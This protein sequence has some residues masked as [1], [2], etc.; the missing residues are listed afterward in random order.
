MPPTSLESSPK[1]KIVLETGDAFASGDIISGHVLRQSPIVDPNTSISL[2]LCA[3]SRSYTAVGGMGR[4]EFVSTFNLLDS[5]RQVLQIH[6][7]PIHIP[8][9]SPDSDYGR[10]PF[11]ITLPKHPDFAS[12]KKDNEDEKTFLPFEDIASKELPPSFSVNTGRGTPHTDAFVEYYLE[13]TMQCNGAQKHTLMSRKKDREFQAILPLQIRADLPSMSRADFSTQHRAEPKQRLVS[14][15]LV[16]GVDSRLGVGQHIRKMVKSSQVPGYSFSLQLDFAT[17]LQI[18]NPNPIPLQ[19]LA[20]TV[21]ADTSDILQ[22]MLPTILVKQFKLTLLSTALCTSRRFKTLRV[23]GL[24]G[25]PVKSTS[26]LVDY[27][28]TSG[29]KPASYANGTKP[30]APSNI[31]LIV[32]QDD[33]TPLDLGVA[34]SIR[35]PKSSSGTSTYPTFTTCNIKVTHAIEWSITLSIAGETVKYQDQQ[36]VTVL[37]PSNKA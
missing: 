10:W 32:P 26:T 19:L 36:P 14:Q 3:R 20:N 27:T 24:E 21:W 30:K 29:P 8:P 18:G 23:S 33:P 9:N 13:A 6:R 2:R 1:L 22:Q 31:P 15:R 4:Q 35:P 17:L 37:G 16:L 11:A 34:L 25:F 7:G 5:S 28:W 12:L